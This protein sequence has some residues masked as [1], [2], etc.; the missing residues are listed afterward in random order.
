MQSQNGL[1]ISFNRDQIWLQSSQ[2][3]VREIRH[4]T[5]GQFS[6]LQGYL[7]PFET[8][9]KSV[10]GLQAYLVPFETEIAVIL[11]PDHYLQAYLVPIIKIIAIISGPAL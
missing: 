8:D 4:L 6:T 9:C 2:V 3:C 1:A 5:L 7:V 10:L 11:G